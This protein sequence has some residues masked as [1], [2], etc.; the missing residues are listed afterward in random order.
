[1]IP[2]GRVGAFNVDLD[3]VDPVE[4]LVLARGLSERVGSSP[5]FDVGVR[6]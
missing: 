1:M 2:K 5:R 4:W 3:R 6:R